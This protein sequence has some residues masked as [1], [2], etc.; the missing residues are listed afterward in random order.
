MAK[1][2]NTNDNLYWRGCGV[3]GTLLHCWWECQLYK[4]SGNQYR[5]FSE[6]WESIYLRT[7]QLI[8]LFGTYPKDAQ[9]YYKDIC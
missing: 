9:S 5:D 3:R 8:P 2:K 6:N 4:H 7:Q 1:I